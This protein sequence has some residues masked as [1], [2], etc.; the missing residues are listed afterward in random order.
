M[1][2]SGSVVV[3][4]AASLSTVRIMDPVGLP[5]VGL[6]TVVKRQVP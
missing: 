2:S 3:D 1:R 6:A 5:L 4:T